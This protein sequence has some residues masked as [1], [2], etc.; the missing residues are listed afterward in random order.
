MKGLFKSTCAMA[1]L[2]VASTVCF[3]STAFAQ[4]AS[5]SQNSTDDAKAE[6]LQGLDEIIVT[7]RRRQERVQDTPISM[8]ALSGDTLSES[9]TRTIGDLAAIAPSLFASGSAAGAGTTFFAIRGQ[10]QLDSQVATDPSVALYLDDVYIATSN[11]VLNDLTDIQRVEVLKGPQGTLFGRNT[12]GG[13]IAVYSNPPTY[14]LGGS[15]R[16][17]YGSFDSFGFEGVLNVPIVADKAALRLVGVTSQD[18]GYAVNAVSGEA[19][20]KQFSRQARGTLLLEPVDNFS[21]TIRADYSLLRNRGRVTKLAYIEPAAVNPFNPSLAVTAIESGLF[22]GGFPDVFAAE[23]A[24]APFLNASNDRIAQTNGISPSTGLQANFARFEQ[25]GVSARAELELGDITLRSITAYRELD[26]KSFGDADATPFS[27]L[28]YETTL[29]PKQFSQEFQILGE[30]FDNRLN[31]VAGA[32]FYQVKGADGSTAEN[33]SVLTGQDLTGDGIPDILNPNF[34]LGD[35]DNT[36]RAVFAQG[37]FKLSDVFSITAGG[38]YTSE[39][40]TLDLTSTAGGLCSLPPALLVSPGVCQTRLSNKFDGWS[41]IFSLEYKPNNDL[42]A[43]AKTT[44]GFRSG[45]QNFCA[46]GDVAAF[47]PFR[48]EIVT[49]YELGL[50]SEFFDR[51]VRFN[52]AAFYSNYSDIQRVTQVP[53]GGGAV[54]AITNAAKARIYGVEVETLA[55]PLEG[56]TLGANLGYINARYKEFVDVLGDR[57]NEPFVL[58]PEFSYSL[59]GE[60][61]FDVGDAG[62]LKI[63]GDWRWVDAVDYGRGGPGTRE[64]SYGLMNGRISFTT[65]DNQLEFAAFARNLFNKKYNEGRFDFVDTLGFAV[66]YVGDPRTFG[67]EA[68]IRFG[69]EK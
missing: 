24:L 69:G 29:D 23:A 60:Y 39:R 61:G 16:A 4:S 49:D 62:T 9:G 43:Y 47:A 42:L 27:I 25:W 33:L 28:Q 13:A 51:R 18:D 6:E 37:T 44:R 35:N 5:T 45:G 38:R 20:G 66:A 67:V 46:R 7:A 48:P 65:S 14:D 11:G 10:T 59:F 57:T 15:F 22:A 58:T 31:W 19:L 3:G 8:T 52:L 56:L 32:Y 63:R 68:K 53:G 64:P 40:K 1:A 54:Q 34:S 12:T 41:Y 36:S 55:S 17:R 30:S 21:L 26:G 50:K 2:T